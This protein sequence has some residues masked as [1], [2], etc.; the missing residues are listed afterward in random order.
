MRRRFG[1]CLAAAIIGAGASAAVAQTYPSRPIVL[2]IGVAP[3]GVADV[4]ARGFADDVAKDLR[5]PVTVENRASFSGAEAAEIVQVPPPDGYRLLIFSGAQHLGLP[6]LRKTEY[7]PINGF[8]PVTTLFTLVNFLAVPAKS[9]ANTVPELIE[10]GRAKA[11][12]F[13]SSGVGSTSHLT[14]MSLAATSKISIAP[15]HYPGARPML[16]DLLAGRLDFTLVSYTL[17][18]GAIAAQRLKLLAVDAP[19]RWP[20]LPNMPTLKEAG[21]DQPRVASWFALA[22]PA[23]TPAPIIRRLHDAFAKA[24]SRPA[25]QTALRENGVVITAS[26]PEELQAMMTRERETMAALVQQLH[27]KE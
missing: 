26:T 18:K 20:D 8:A 6:A 15:T 27:L 3:G 14:A 13:G 24:A 21:I 17:L 4:I 9:P 7:D 11:L 16:N 23:R 5:Q 19:E 2:T 25:M 1:I 22:A 12:R 10:Q